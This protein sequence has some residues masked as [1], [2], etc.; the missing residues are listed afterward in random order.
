MFQMRI[1]FVLLCLFVFVHADDLSPA[2]LI[3]VKHITNDVIAQ[4]MDLTLEYTL[5][6]VGERYI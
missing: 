2:R 1:S 4:G 5:Y 6:N 3:V